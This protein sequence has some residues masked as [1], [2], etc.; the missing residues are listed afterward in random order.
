MCA[1]T[2]DIGATTCATTQDIGATLCA[3]RKK[4]DGT[5][6]IFKTLICLASPDPPL[7]VMAHIPYALY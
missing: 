1:T 5:I 2:Q 6:I 3:T 4:S 7:K